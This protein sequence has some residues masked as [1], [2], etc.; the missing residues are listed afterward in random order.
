M[1]TRSMLRHNV[2]DS[3]GN[4]IQNALVYVYETGTTTAVADMYA[5]ASGGSPIT[6]LTSNAQ[7]EV[8]AWFT[9]PRF[10]DLLVTDN[11]DAAYY[12]SASAVPLNWTNFTETV[13]VIAADAVAAGSDGWLKTYGADPDLITFGAIT[14][15]S[16]GAVTS[17]ALVWPD[18]T[19][20]TFTADTLST[21]F[22]GSVDAYHV[23]YGSPATKTVTQ[24]AVTRDS[25]T[26]AVST[27]P[28]LVV[29]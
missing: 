10:V 24:P 8:T 25:S 20:G 19:A 15:D 6:T 23:T 17:A 14:R 3:A 13:Q 28:A 9:T 16:N 4:V 22:P 12:P 27:R 7:G 29:T 1:T 5:A 26:G 11:T 2:A 21:A 18:G